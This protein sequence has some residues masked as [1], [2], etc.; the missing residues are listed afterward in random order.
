MHANVSVLITPLP[1]FF[2]KTNGTIFEANEMHLHM[3]SMHGL[4]WLVRCY[5]NVTLLIFTHNTWALPYK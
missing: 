2:K 3:Q 1:H 4:T 5:L